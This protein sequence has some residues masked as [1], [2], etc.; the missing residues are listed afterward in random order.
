MMTISL[1]F[2]YVCVCVCIYIYIYICCEIVKISFNKYTF[3]KLVV[4]VQLCSK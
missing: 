4:T 3:F 2:I 1:Y